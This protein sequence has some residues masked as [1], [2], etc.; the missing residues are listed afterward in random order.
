MRRVVPPYGVLEVQ[1]KM[2][3]SCI[4]RPDSTLDLVA[5]EAAIADPRMRGFFFVGYRS[6]HHAPDRRA[7][8]CRGFWDRH[9]D[10]F[11][12]GQLAQRLKR[13]RFVTVDRFAETAKKGRRR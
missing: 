4:Y 12:L 9:K 1:R 7:V 2:C 13:L 11:T 10:H 5:L 3:A 8:C 6:C